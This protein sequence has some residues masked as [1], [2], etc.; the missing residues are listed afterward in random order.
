MTTQLEPRTI[1]L[2]AELAR[3]EDDARSQSA[4]RWRAALHRLCI[5]RATANES[6]YEAEW[7][8]IFDQR[9]LLA[10]VQRSKLLSFAALDVLEIQHEHEM[11]VCQMD[12]IPYDEQKADECGELLAALRY[13]IE[14]GLP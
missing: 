6:S 2:S 13:K 12:E 8:R 4:K 3:S 10:D 11:L 1:S 9:T 14:H 5:L 7:P